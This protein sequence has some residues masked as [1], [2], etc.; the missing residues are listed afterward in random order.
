LIHLQSGLVLRGYQRLV[1]EAVFDS[2][3]NQRGLSLVVM[4]PRQSG[5]NE[6]Q[7]QL[8][9]LLLATYADL[10]GEMVKISPTWKPQTY[11]AMR[12]LERTLRASPLASGRWERKAGYLYCLG[13][14]C[15]AFLSGS[16]SANIIGAT[17][18]LM[19]AVDEAQEIQID[20]FDREIAPMA[21]STNATRIFWGTAWT[22]QTLLGRELH[23]A[24]AAEQRDGVRRAFVLDAERV[25]AEVPPYA[26]FVHE[27]VH[28]LGRQHPLVRT[29]YFS[30]EIDGQTGLFPP[31]RL[32]RLGGAHPAED[33]PTP[34]AVYAVLVD[35]GGEEA[36][37]AGVP[38]GQL[39]IQLPGA[40]PGGDPLQPESRRDSSAATVVRIET[41]L[42]ASEAVYRVVQRRLWTGASH[43]RLITELQALAEYWNCAGVVIDA[44]GI[45]AG[46]A[47]FLARALGEP[48]VQRFVF[49][50]ASKSQLGWG[51]L[52]LVETGRF[53]DHAPPADRF[54]QAAILQNLFL[55]QAASC[56]A[57]VGSGQSLHWGVPSG[58]RHPH[59]HAPLHDDLLL[60]A[61]L[62]AALEGQSWHSGPSALSAPRDPV[63]GLEEAF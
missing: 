58:V 56:R 49:S 7:A 22:S 35:V 6:L 59:S 9:A 8:E 41:G 10:G 30:E 28:R 42:A 3:I 40:E 57:E 50:A 12:R 4:M 62:C 29:Q 2:V 45:G 17:A 15:L 61:A 39:S 47:A 53:L 37:A 1:A 34:G 36:H 13:R 19:L 44:T 20:K 38:P 26:A 27:Q 51:F 55:A 16:P 5:K 23:A 24:R 52:A 18:S 43:T 25:M 33:T 11:N 14:A 63:A 46:L 48:R 60:S 54:S 32:A 31:E 21:A